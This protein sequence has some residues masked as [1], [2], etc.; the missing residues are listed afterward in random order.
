[1]PDETYDAIIVGAGNKA[2]IVAM[3]LAK[4]GGMS[5]ALFEKRHEAGGGWCSDEG[6]APGFIADYHATAVGPFW[7]TPT[8]WDFSEWAELGVRYNEA[9]LGSGA[10][11]KENDE[12]LVIYNRKADPTM[13]KSA[14]SI[15]RFSKRDAET[16]VRLQP[17][18]GKI[19]WK[20]MLEWVHNPPT[21]PG[22]PDA[23]ERMSMD[24][25]LKKY[26]VDPSWIVKSPLD[27]AREVF[28]SDEMI[29]TAMRYNET[30]V[31]NPPD[32]PYTGIWAFLYS[33]SLMRPLHAGV[34]GGTHNWAHA[35]VKIVLKYGGKVFTKHEVDK[36]VIENG[37]ATGIKLVDGTEVGAR[38]C[39]VTTIDPYNLCFRLIGKEHLSWSILRKIENLERRIGIITWYTWALHEQPKY[40]SAKI[41]PDIDKAMSVMLISKDPE[42]LC[43]EMAQRKLGIMPHDLQL[44]ITNHSLVDKARVPE[45]KASILTEQFVIPADLM[46]ERQW[47]SYKKEHAE[48][49][50]KCLGEHSHNMTWDNVLGYVANSPY[51]HC[52][53][54]NMA[55]TGNQFVIDNTP[56]Q[57]GRN[58]PI[59]EF[60]SY[61]TPIKNLYATG[62]GW[63]P[64]GMSACWG[65]YCCY[66]ILAEDYGLTKPWQKEGRP[67]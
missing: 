8:E 52:K 27:V 63:H 42:A 51:D 41:N 37:K 13:E 38:K 22:V 64:M 7:Q 19:Y 20:A 1:M 16:W 49:V 31:G 5:V 12:P 56:G 21:P 11:F 55:P 44:N 28:E 17:L 9:E 62:S 53:L 65:G 32:M 35:A 29:A 54:A 39:V 4:Y 10:I 25:E 48:E 3:Y 36:V 50:M 40:T 47:A 61:R 26:G 57:L 43:R 66:K 23:I 46:T 58:R 60:S 18:F 45:G 2:L 59:P 15:A 33:V 67:W 34:A 24:P 30:A 14:A 6:A